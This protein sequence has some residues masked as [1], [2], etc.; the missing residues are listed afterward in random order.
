MNRDFH[1]KNREYQQRYK[2]PIAFSNKYTDKKWE[3]KTEVKKHYEDRSKL[4]N[5]FNRK[6][7]YSQ[8]PNNL[9]Q[10]STKQSITV[11]NNIPLPNSNNS[12]YIKH[13]GN[14]ICNFFL[15]N[16]NLNSNIETGTLT[17]VNDK[18]NGLQMDSNNESIFLGKKTNPCFD[19]QIL[20]NGS[21]TFSS[22][23]SF[24]KDIPNSSLNQ[25]V[26][27]PRLDESQSFQL[28]SIVTIDLSKKESF[29]LEERESKVQPV[30]SDDLNDTRLNDPIEDHSNEDY[31]VKKIN[32][33]LFKMNSQNR[34]EGLDRKNDYRFDANLFSVFLNTKVSTKLMKGIHNTEELNKLKSWGLSLLKCDDKSTSYSP[35]SFSHLPVILMTKEQIYGS[36]KINND[37][38]LKE[39]KS[40]IN[41]IRIKKQTNLKEK[42][43]SMEKI[44][45]VKKKISLLKVKSEII[46]DMI[47]DKDRICKEVLKEK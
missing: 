34:N 19:S 30:N 42:L 40:H 7:N 38:K 5:P 35:F 46:D 3:E 44:N 39:L 1:M 11:N 29:L 21:T 12:E 27:S 13:Y 23:S 24:S 28:E 4:N 22:K 31:F 20:L 8:F 9:N 18:Q 47:K 37:N 25:S 45:E 10:P 17:H 41:S 26:S 32:E 16:Q 14:F 43:E 33:T 15:N 36:K 6:F 2:H